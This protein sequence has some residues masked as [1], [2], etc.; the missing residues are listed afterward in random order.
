MDVG[1]YYIN[2]NINIKHCDYTNSLLSS[3]GVLF[4]VQVK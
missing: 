4:E 1:M 3:L 2:I